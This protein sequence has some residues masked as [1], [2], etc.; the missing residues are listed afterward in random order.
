[1]RPLIEGP[2]ALF[3]PRTSLRKVIHAVQVNGIYVPAAHQIPSC[4]FLRSTPSSYDAFRG[5]AVGMLLVVEDHTSGDLRMLHSLVPTIPTNCISFVVSQALRRRL[6]RMG[7]I[8]VSKFLDGW[9]AS[10]LMAA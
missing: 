2:P 4:S 7:C 9:S 5:N 8:V 10:A 1:M 6:C 3:V